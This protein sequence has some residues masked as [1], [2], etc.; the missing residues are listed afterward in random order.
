M[1]IQKIQKKKRKK[2]KN[3]PIFS[4]L[5]NDPLVKKMINLLMRHGKKSKAEKVLF[6]A[7]E[8][9]DN[10][11]PNKALKIFY[12]AVIAVKQDIGVSLKPK[13]KKGR[14]KHS[15]NVYIPRTIS[16]VRGLSL[17]IRLIVKAS[18]EHS[19]AY[20][21]PFWESLSQELLQASQNKGEVVAKRYSNN[22]LAISNK[23]R[24]HFKIRR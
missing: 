20:F 2:K 18:R 9:L 4:K 8:I 13:S 5:K 15:Y 16:A 6:K 12:F 19:R 3:V 7:F 1:V 21:C 14:R 17:G 11:Y 23:R 24:V 22:E 10:E